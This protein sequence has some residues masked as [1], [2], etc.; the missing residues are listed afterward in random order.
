MFYRAGQLG[1][2]CLPAVPGPLNQNSQNR[3]FGS[4]SC[5]P[6]LRSS[7]AFSCVLGQHLARKKLKFERKFLLIDF[8]VQHEQ[9]SPCLLFFS[10][11]PLYFWDTHNFFCLDPRALQC[12]YNGNKNLSFFL[13]SLLKN[14]FLP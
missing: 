12:V 9:H 6:I 3:K 13:F 4:S 10:K 2:A 7:Q 1:F 11:I 14:I 8:Q 5:S